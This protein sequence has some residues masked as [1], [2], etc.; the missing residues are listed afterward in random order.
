MI[1]EQI[2]T[3]PGGDGERAGRVAGL[4]G[5]VLCGGQSRRMGRPKAWLP[6]GGEALLQRVVRRLGEAAWPIAVV[7]APG[8]E[9]PPLPDGALLVRDPVEG[10][11]PMQGI[12]VGLEAVAPLAERA[13]VTST[14]APFLHPA[15]VRRLAELQAGGPAIAVPRADG[16]HHPLCAV[17]ACS[18]RGEAAALLAEGQLRLTT[19]FERARTLV[20]GPELLLEDPGLGAADPDLRSLRNVN[21]PEEYAAALREL[22]G[23]PPG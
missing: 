1:Q 16:R 4:A 15:L 12:A 17:Y 14:D 10:R 5:V 18:V 22:Y 6:F 19:L 23:A 21:T 20:A 9:L 7:A 13:L 2:V 8:Q 3:A 11:G